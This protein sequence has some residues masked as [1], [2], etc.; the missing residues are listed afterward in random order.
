MCKHVGCVKRVKKKRKK[1][2][3]RKRKKEKERERNK[4]CNRLQ[5]SSERTSVTCRHFSFFFLARHPIETVHFCS[6]SQLIF[7]P[8]LFLSLSLL[9]L[10]SSSHSLLFKLLSNSSHSNCN[11]FSDYFINHFIYI[12]IRIGN[13]SECVCQMKMLLTQRARSEREEELVREREREF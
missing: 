11:P 3:E 10:F 5:F 7:L 2:R 9:I 8:F 12:I 4:N 13:E 1:E 6:T